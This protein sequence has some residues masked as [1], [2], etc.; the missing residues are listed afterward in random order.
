MRVS[1]ISSRPSQIERTGLLAHL[2]KGRDRLARRRSRSCLRGWDTGRTTS[3]LMMIICFLHRCRTRAGR[4]KGRRS[5][6]WGRSRGSR[7]CG[8]PSDH[9]RLSCLR[10]STEGCSRLYQDCRTPFLEGASRSVNFSNALPCCFNE[11]N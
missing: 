7:R 3:Y 9:T 2:Q 1:Q 5:Q 6:T 11:V 8:S 10:S 4:Y